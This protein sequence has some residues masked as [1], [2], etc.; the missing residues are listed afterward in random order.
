MIIWQAESVTLL[1]NRLWH[2]SPPVNFEKTEKFFRTAQN[3]SGRLLL[4]LHSISFLNFNKFVLKRLQEDFYFVNLTLNISNKDSKCSKIC[5]KGP[6]K[7]L[8]TPFKPM[9]HLYV[10]ICLSDSNVNLSI[11]RFSDV[12]RV[13]RFLYDRNLRQERVIVKLEVNIIQIKYS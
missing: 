12:L 2:R 3:T 7:N 1:K 13:Q 8:L 5:Y 9:F 4:L 6:L 10:Y 11:H